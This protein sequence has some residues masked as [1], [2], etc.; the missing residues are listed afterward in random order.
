MT[1]WTL[2]YVHRYVENGVVVYDSE[3]LG[4]YTSEEKANKAAELYGQDEKYERFCNDDVTEWGEF[5]VKEVVLDT[6]REDEEL[7]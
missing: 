3:L 7:H 2:S 1:I 4:A 6:I 5:E